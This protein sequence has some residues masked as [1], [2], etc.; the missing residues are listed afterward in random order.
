[1]KRREFIA[2]LGVAAAWPLAARAQQSSKVK[3]IA[4]V[5]PSTPIT[6]LTQTGSSGYRFLLKE[7]RRLGH[8]EG[9]NLAVERYSGHGQTEHYAELAREVA[10]QAPDL[11]VTNASRLV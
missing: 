10:R 8:V 1:M 3:R 2:G 7:L 6:E 9:E 11:I 4:V 5:H